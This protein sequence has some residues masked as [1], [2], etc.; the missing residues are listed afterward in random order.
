MGSSRNLALLYSAAFLRSAS[1]GLLGVVLAV[2][3]SRAGFSATLIGFVLAAGLAGNAAATAAASRYGDRLG[4]RRIL[5]VAGVVSS[6]GGLGLAFIHS[7]A[8]LIPLA[9]LCMLNGMGTDRSAAFAVEQAVIPGLV[10]DRARTWALSWYNVALDT[11]G[12]LGA[13]AGGLPVAIDTWV[14][15]GLLPAY[16]WVFF[17]YTALN[18]ASAALYLFLDSQVESSAAPELERVGSPI[19]PATKRIVGRI[20]ALFALDSAGGGFLADA[21]L[22]YWFFHRFAVNEKELGLLFFIVRLLNGLSHLGAAWLARRI[23]LL[24]TMV[25]TH[26]PSSLFLLAVPFAPNFHLAALLL[27]LREALVEMDVP[28]RQSYVAAVVQPHERVYASGITNLTRTGAWAVTASAAGAL[29]QHVAFSA[30]LVL[31]GGLKV[32]YDL[33]LYR[34]FRHL[35]PPEE[36]LQSSESASG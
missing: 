32:I 15:L 6:F 9:F 30:P 34:S 21:L 25:F 2:Y 26:L 36:R 29:M 31:G 12:A 33:L 19:S 20:S 4:R 14:G 17:F 24:R 1:V 27:F 3:L 7:A 28:T 23:G 16:R 8:V 35:K 10:T 5:V 22:A 11:S 18:L 13:L